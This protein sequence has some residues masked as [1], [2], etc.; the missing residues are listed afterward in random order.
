MASG[1]LGAGTTVS[2][3]TTENGAYTSVGEVI[4]ANPGDNN[5]G[6][7]IDMT[8]YLSPNN[9]ME[10]KAG[11]TD[12]TEA[13]FQINF[14]PSQ[15]ARLH[16]LLGDDMWWKITYRD[17]SYDKFP[18]YISRLSRAIPIKDRVTA[19]ITIQKTGAMKFVEYS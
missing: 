6:D 8:H 16:D 3:S 2:Y 15:Y 17:G 13:T 11:W 4:D 9:T 12:P 14:V 1:L 19:T 10:Y 18:G 5:A 7:R